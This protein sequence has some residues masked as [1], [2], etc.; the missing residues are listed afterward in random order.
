MQEGRGTPWRVDWGL[1][2]LAWGVGGGPAADSGTLV[3]HCDHD[4][5]WK[6][7]MSIKAPWHA[8]AMI[9]SPPASTSR[10]YVDCPN[11]EPH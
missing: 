3:I 1:G 4:P 5:A 9:L 11:N 7:K 6:S 8:L 10:V 2:G